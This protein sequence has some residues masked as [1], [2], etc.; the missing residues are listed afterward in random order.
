MTIP[1]PSPASFRILVCDELAPQALEIFRTTLPS[2]RNAI[3]LRLP[4]HPRR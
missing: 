2:V 3:N 1:R 4:S